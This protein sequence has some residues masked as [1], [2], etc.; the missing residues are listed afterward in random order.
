[1]ATLFLRVNINSLRVSGV[2]AAFGVRLRIPDL[3]AGE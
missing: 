3:K 2:A 1:M